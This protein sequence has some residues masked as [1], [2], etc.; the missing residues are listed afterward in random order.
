M[1]GIVL[2]ILITMVILFL[3]LPTLR[4]RKH[5]HSGELRPE[6]NYP[7]LRTLVGIIALSIAS[8]S[9]LATEPTLTINSIS[10]SYHTDGHDLFVGQL[11]V[12]S[13]FLLAYQGREEEAQK[14]TKGNITEFISAKIGAIAIALT[15]LLPTSDCPYDLSGT[16]V[17]CSLNVPAYLGMDLGETGVWHLRFAG[18][19][20]IAL[21][22]I[23]GTFVWRAFERATAWSYARA[24]VY[25]GCMLGMLYA[26]VIF[27]LA[28]FQQK[29][30]VAELVAL[31]SFG[32]GWILAGTY[33]TVGNYIDSMKASQKK[34]GK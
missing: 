9:V 15:A 11:F 20:F 33:A 34:E 26:V 17:D 8:F 24:V 3:V 1:S 29:I 30:F 6:F 4:A 28:D 23:L 18:L 7:V 19:F 2:I 31:V 25:L 27:A 21:A 16:V 14:T 5:A 32:I 22:V 13:A 10:A 12:V